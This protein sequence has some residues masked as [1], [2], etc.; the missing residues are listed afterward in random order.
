MFVVALKDDEALHTSPWNTAHHC[1]Q[2]I[3][4]WEGKL[5]QWVQLLEF[6][7]AKVE[8]T[9][10]CSIYVAFTPQQ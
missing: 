2:C 8:K 9:N 10:A 6:S 3:C 1:T 5:Q 7:V 4:L